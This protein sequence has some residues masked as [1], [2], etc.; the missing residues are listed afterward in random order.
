MIGGVI[1][2]LSQ[3]FQL[4]T[5]HN[6]LA[7]MSQ[8]FQLG[9]M[10]SVVDS[11]SQHFQL[12]NVHN[13]MHDPN[14][15]THL[16]AFA[17]GVLVCYLRYANVCTL[18]SHPKT[19]PSQ[20]HSTE[21]LNQTQIEENYTSDTWQR[22]A[23]DA[24]ATT[25]L[26]RDRIFPCIYAS[27]GFKAQE[28]SYLFLPSSNLLLH[29]TLAATARALI[30]YQARART[31]GPHTSLVIFAPPPTQPL[32]VA[33]YHTRFWAF[34]RALHKLDPAPWPADVPTDMRSERWCFCFNGTPG[35]VGVMTP[36]HSQRLSR[37]APTLCLVYQP[38]FLFDNLFRTEK[39]RLAAAATVR[40]LIDKYDLL[41]RSPD[42]SHYSQ[43]GTTETKQYFL[44]DENEPAGCGYE[45]LGG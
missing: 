31:L 27:K 13:L 44:L 25:L 16:C 32:S 28:L 14:V 24:L 30:S 19:D 34:L 6:M 43:P 22:Q 35:F 12:D 2:D 23:Y 9:P 45:T 26:A 40:G 7:D 39:S 38:R 36:A 41:P 4:I 3:R 42:I 18:R 37:H 20:E 8:P 21:L 1:D 5:M 11:L 17:L 29:R 33:A 10:H 15:F